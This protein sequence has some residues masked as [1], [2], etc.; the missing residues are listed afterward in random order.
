MCKNNE[1]EMNATPTAEK[2]NCDEILDTTPNVAVVPIKFNKEVRNLTIDEASVLAQKGLK[3]DTIQ[4]DYELLRQLAVE[5]NM[6]VSSFLK[7]LQDEEENR[8]LISLTEK[9][10]GD[11]ELAAHILELEKGKKTE[12]FDLAEL[13]EYFPNI[14]SA[15]MLPSQVLE[16]AALS[17]R[18][19]LDEYLR[20]SRKEKLKVKEAEKN[21]NTALKLSSGTQINR[22][23]HIAPETAEFLKGLWN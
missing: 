4:K 5:K 6:S 9:C 12:N 13:M 19:L 21:Y 11:G 14:K 20:Y 3:F 8:R 23:G 10:G 18:N 15:D 1:L 16:N 22:M 2:E 17:G 7:S